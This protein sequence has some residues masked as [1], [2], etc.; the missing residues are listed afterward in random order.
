MGERKTSVPRIDGNRKSRCLLLDW[1]DTVMRVFPEFDGPM[2]TW[3]RV[4]AVDGIEEALEILRPDWTIALAT[5]AADSKEQEIWSALSRAGLE[6]QIDRIYCFRGV[7]HRKSEPAYFEY[8]LADLGIGA[9]AAVM[10]GDDF[11]ADVVSANR[12][13]IRAIWFCESA[14]GGPSGEMHRTIRDLRELP[15]ALER[16]W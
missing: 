6:H 3:P 11:E 12:A 14:T 16:P 13:G 5:N 2:Y 15:E 1:G 9:D 10:V 8:V 4:A 7:G